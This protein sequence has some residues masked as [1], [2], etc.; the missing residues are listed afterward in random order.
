MVMEDKRIQKTNETIK[1]KNQNKSKHKSKHRPHALRRTAP[2]VE[3]AIQNFQKAADY[4]AW[5]N[6]LKNFFLLNSQRLTTECLDDL[7]TRSN[8]MHHYSIC[9]RSFVYRELWNRFD[10]SIHV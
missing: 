8:K 6:P 1:T 7:M 10:L 5:L 3:K 2:A 4:N 9:I